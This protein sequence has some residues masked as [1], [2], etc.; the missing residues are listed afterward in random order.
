MMPR[1]AALRFIITGSIALLVQALPAPAE[2][3]AAAFAKRQDTMKRM[4]RSFFLSI[5]RVV[6]GKAAYG[7]DTVKAA[8][9][10]ASLVNTLD[11]TSSFLAPMS[12]TARS[13][14]RYSLPT[15]RSSG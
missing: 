11:W 12:R 10:V 2:D 14:P 4:G 9:T 3:G 13:S 5:G 1:R 6:K 8:E 7:P 15:T